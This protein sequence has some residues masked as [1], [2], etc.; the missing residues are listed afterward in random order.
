MAIAPVTALHRFREGCEG[1]LRAL[2]SAR[3]RSV[4]T[5]A[6]PCARRSPPVAT[7]GGEG[8]DALRLDYGSYYHSNQTIP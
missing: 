5:K 7:R 6:R 4:R 8:G 2:K 3:A 1:R